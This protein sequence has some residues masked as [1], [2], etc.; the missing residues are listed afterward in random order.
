MKSA[1]ERHCLRVEAGANEGW[2][3]VGWMPTAVV[4]PACGCGRSINA[5][6]APDFIQQRGGG[7]F[8]L[9]GN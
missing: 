6:A 9:E 5:L 8:M 2:V 1:L 7:A 4:V 3:A